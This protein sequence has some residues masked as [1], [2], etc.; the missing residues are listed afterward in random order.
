MFE[1][2]K[3]LT[4]E[5]HEKFEKYNNIKMLNNAVSN[6]NGDIVL[7]YKETEGSTLASQYKRN[8]DFYNI[9]LNQSERAQ[10]VRLDS[11]IE[12]ESLSHIDLFKIDI[13]GNELKALEGMGNYLNADFVDFI[14]FEYGGCNLDSHTSLMEI[15]ALLTSKGFKI[16]R[17]TKKGLCFYD[18]NPNMDNFMYCNYVAVSKKILL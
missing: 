15:Y 7:L 9:D 5:L 18:Y 12:K 14:Q 17:I 16:A 3:C 8:L 6:T 10:T 11:F 2:Q 13:E 1:A 4:E